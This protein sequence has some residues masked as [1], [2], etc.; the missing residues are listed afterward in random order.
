MNERLARI[1]AM[2]L[3]ACAGMLDG[4]FAPTVRQ[5]RQPPP[6]WMHKKGRNR[7]KKMRRKV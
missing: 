1:A 6:E 4:A 5:R 2:S 7:K 3:I